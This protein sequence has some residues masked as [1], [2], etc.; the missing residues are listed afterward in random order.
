M[1]IRYETD[2]ERRTRQLNWA[3]QKGY[4][5]ARAAAISDIHW[6]QIEFENV[7]HR[8]YHFAAKLMDAYWQGVQEF[9]H[10]QTARA[11]GV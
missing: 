5:E 4:R 6:L 10:E 7:C 11:T 2:T 3:R 1:A 8:D 9:G